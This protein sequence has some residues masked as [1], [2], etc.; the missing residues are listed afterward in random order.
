MQWSRSMQLSYPLKTENF[1]NAVADIVLNIVNI[2]L[3]TL[4]IIIK[5]NFRTHMD[6]M[7]TPARRT[8]TGKPPVSGWI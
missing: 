4:H 2:T 1:P 3:L 5:F 6:I 7:K 8:V